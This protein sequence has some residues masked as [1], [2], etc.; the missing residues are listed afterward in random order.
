MLEL[1]K[2]A[3]S[4]ELKLTVPSDSHRATI[5][6]LPIDPV[7]AQPRQ[8]FF[9]D[10]PNLDLDKAGLV[11]RARRIQ[12]GRGDSV[13]KLRPVVPNE[14]P[15]E[16]RRSAAFN[17]EVDAMPGGYVCS[18]SMKGRS[19]SAEISDAVRGALPLRKTFTKE[20]R[21]FFAANARRPARLDALVPLGP[22]YVPARLGP[23]GSRPEVRGGAWPQDGSQFRLSTVLPPSETFQVSQRRG[24]ICRASA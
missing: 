11:V 15:D 13:V 14:L 9:F 16:V 12:G 19:S 3:D 21:T 18:G 23:E 7:E 2:N 4:V 10:T 1:V 6:G 20:Q 8:V 17:V 5:Q 24:P 22:T